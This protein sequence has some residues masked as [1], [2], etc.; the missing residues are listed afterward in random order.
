MEIGYA[1]GEKKRIILAIKRD[2]KDFN[3]QLLVSDHIASGITNWNGFDLECIEKVELRGKK[4]SLN[5]HAVN[6][7]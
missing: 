4:E 7:I 3:Q 6:L 1:L 5:I 2:V